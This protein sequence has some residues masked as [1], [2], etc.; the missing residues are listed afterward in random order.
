[1]KPFQLGPRLRG[2]GSTYNGN[3]W[4]ILPPKDGETLRYLVG[5]V[6]EYSEWFMNLRDD[7]SGWSTCLINPIESPEHLEELLTSLR[8]NTNGKS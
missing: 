1:M 3:D 2:I 4:W 5:Y 8:I 7:F 6:P